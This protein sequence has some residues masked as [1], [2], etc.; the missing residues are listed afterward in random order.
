MENSYTSIPRE[1]EQQKKIL[2][3]EIVRITES[4]SLKAVGPAFPVTGADAAEWVNSGRL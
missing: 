3:Q 2:F 1:G 4:L